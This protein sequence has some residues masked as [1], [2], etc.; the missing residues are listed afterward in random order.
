MKLKKE[1]M[2]LAVI[3]VALLLY[4]LLKG[5]DKTHYSLPELTKIAR[6]DV[7][8]L[9]IIRPGGT[10]TLEGR[11]EEWKIQPQGYPADKNSVDRM[12]KAVEEFELSTLVSES[13][14]YVQFD[15]A[16]D[17]KIIL[18]VFAGETSLAKLDIGKTATTYQH[19]YVRLAGDDK[20][21]QARGNIRQP[22]DIEMDR[23]R[24][25]V[26]AKIERDFVTGIT[27]QGDGEPLIIQKYEEPPVPMTT[28]EDS[29][30]AAPPQ[31]PLWVTND[32]R[33]AQESVING[34]I[35]ALANLRCAEYIDGKSKE[36][37]TIPAYTITVEST[38]FV[39][40]EIF[41][42]QEDNKYPAISSQ[43]DYPFLLTEGVVNR[44]KKTPDELL[45]QTAEEE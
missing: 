41:D 22:L 1:Y 17:K 21:Y 12:L 37:Y 34:I 44:L 35:G 3:V 38:S 5:T 24:D 29:V 33:E 36:D 7:S 23:L 43:N 25:K 27:M 18:E 31:K 30:A 32:G 10:L 6:A 14:N 2:V 39:T 11:G 16:D 15:L 9:V 26:V 13:K 42:K 19:T 20:V 8:K 4:I 45:V 28:E 40:L